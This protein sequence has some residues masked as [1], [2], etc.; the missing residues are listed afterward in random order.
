MKIKI[1]HYIISENFNLMMKICR[2]K[3][4]LPFK[5]NKKMEFNLRFK[6]IVYEGDDDKTV[7]TASPKNKFFP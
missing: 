7:L 5:I 6:K 4:I 1:N 2:A 3:E